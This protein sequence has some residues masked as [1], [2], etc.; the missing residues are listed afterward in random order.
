MSNP[1]VSVI[2]PTYNRAAALQGAIQS[3]LNQTFEDFELIVVDDASTDNT[4]E[5]VKQ[6]EDSRIRYICRDT[7]RGEA[8]ARNTG[9]IQARGAF[10]AHHDS[11]D[12]WLPEKLEKQLERF[13]GQGDDVG[14][15]YCRFEKV[16][17]EEKSLFPG[18][19]PGQKEGHLFAQLLESN[20]IGTPTVMTRFACVETVGM[21]NESLRNVVDWEMW[22]RL[23][24]RYRILFLDETLVQCDYTGENVSSNPETLI[25]AREYIF[26]AF[27]ADLNEHKTALRKQAV[28]LAELYG[29]T[30][31]LTKARYYYSLALGA[32][33]LH[34][35]VTA[36][37]LSTF[38]GKDLHRKII[39]KLW[40]HS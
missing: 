24:K 27:H 32:S 28:A 35:K 19:W 40:G 33:P 34:P 39:K 37:W 15:V 30:G 17:P 12:T 1:T 38:G 18:D 31:N 2:I 8:A 21:F 9:I 23:A 29:Q 10:I 7:N 13:K 3:V 20:F 11:D 14:A 22:I 16:T 36:A 26:N 6:I 25:R 5:V 4:H